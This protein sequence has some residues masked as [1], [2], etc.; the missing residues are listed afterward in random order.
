MIYIED[1]STS[2]VNKVTYLQWN[3]KI[4]LK[5]LQAFQGDRF[6][7]FKIIKYLQVILH[8]D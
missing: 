1:D 4:I 3:K 7:F 5:K 2:I 6:Y 8:F